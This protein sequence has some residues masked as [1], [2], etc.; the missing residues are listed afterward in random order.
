M[1][2]HVNITKIRK[3]FPNLEVQV[4][5]KPLVYFDNAA[6]TFKPKPVIEALNRYY[7]TGTANVHRGLHYLSEQATQMYEDARKKVQAFLNATESHEIIF[8]KGT[9]ESINLVAQS[10][11]RT[12]LKTDDEV[13]ITEMEHHSNIVPW[14]ILCEQTGIKLKVA[15]ITDA[16]ELDLAAFEKLI[17]SRTKLISVVYISNSLGTVNPVKEIIDMAHQKNIPVL[18][19][20]AQAVNHKIVDVQKLDCDFLA[21]SGHKLFGPTGIGIL[22]GKTKHLEKMPPY[23]G[24]GDMISSVTFAKTIYNTLPYKFEAGTPNIAG[25]IGLGAA[26]DYIQSI[27]LGNL[28]KHEQD[29]VAYGHKA[30]AALKN[31]K[32][33]GTAAEKVPVFSFILPDV[34]A[35][36]L[37]TLIDEEGVAVRTGHHCTQPVMEHFGISAT[38]RASLAFYNTK[39]EIDVLVSAI[40]KAQEVFK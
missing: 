37:G 34:H 7:S 38:T 13:L 12:F 35:H 28:Q 31:L 29:L 9:T 36:D 20:A 25:V 30:L 8:T 16:G 3:D 32:L 33:L 4:H 24:G 26:V 18:L 40:Q 17:T 10:F 39:D 1:D 6:T 27:G 23:Q 19:D 21:C 11:A 15:P 5:G 14:Q 2:Q 22:Y